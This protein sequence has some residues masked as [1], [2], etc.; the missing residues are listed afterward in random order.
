MLTP[1][2]ALPQQTAANRSKS[3]IL[4]LVCNI[5]REPYQGRLVVVSLNLIEEAL[6]LFV[7][8]QHYYRLAHYEITARENLVRCLLLLMDLIKGKVEFDG[9]IRS[10]ALQFH[11]G[12][13]LDVDFIRLL[14]R[15]VKIN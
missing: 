14:P 15:I 3:A 10:Q 1:A 8:V 13:N 9:I 4:L 6:Q 2:K 11:A 7:F 5:L 12:W